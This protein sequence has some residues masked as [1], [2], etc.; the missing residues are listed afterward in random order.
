MIRIAYA[1]D[2]PDPADLL[3]T[4][5]NQKAPPAPVQSSPVVPQRERAPEPVARMAASGGNVTMAVPQES[6]APV[7]RLET[8][9][10][11]VALLTSHKEMILASQVTYFVRLVKMQEGR[12]EVALEPDAPP[13]LT[14]DLRSFLI[15][16]TGRQWMVSISGAPGAPTLARQQEIAAAAMIDEARGHPVVKAA[17]ALF[18]GAAIAIK[19]GE[20]QT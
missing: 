17:L 6:A 19:Q 3:K 2:L 11:A 9:Q 16:V 20:D 14:Q 12:I 7:E 5:K 18:P 1:A 4:L 13:T 15:R 10:E 8:L